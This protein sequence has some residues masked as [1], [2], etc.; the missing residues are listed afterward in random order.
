LTLTSIGLEAARRRWPDPAEV[1]PCH[2]IMGHNATLSWAGHD[3]SLGQ[4]PNDRDAPDLDPDP[5]GT[6]LIVHRAVHGCGM[7]FVGPS[8]RTAVAT[9]VFPMILR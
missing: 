5:S 2:S 6:S 8:G 9:G 3:K 7:T 4:S 1:G